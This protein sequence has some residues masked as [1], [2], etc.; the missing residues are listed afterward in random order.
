MRAA[1]FYT[2]SSLQLRSA[3]VVR[4]HARFLGDP[5]LL[6]TT[7]DRPRLALKRPRDFIHALAKLVAAKEF[8]LLRFGPWSIRPGE[9]T[10]CGLDGRRRCLLARGTT[11]SGVFPKGFLFERQTVSQFFHLF[12]GKK[13]AR[14]RA[15]LS[16]P[17]ADPYLIPQ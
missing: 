15:C 13:I 6:E 10:T 17:V 1:L 12:G 14:L 16:G 2:Q 3:K 11:T 5:Q 7:A 9:L 4:P 8:S